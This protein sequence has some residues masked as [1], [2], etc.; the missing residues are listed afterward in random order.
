MTMTGNEG[1][2]VPITR[3]SDENEHQSGRAMPE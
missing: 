1:H 2:V 3:V